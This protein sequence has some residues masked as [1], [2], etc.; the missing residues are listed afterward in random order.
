MMSDYLSNLSARS[1]NLA[2]V[3]QPRLAS[4]F[5]PLLSATSPRPAWQT[6]DEPAVAEFRGELVNVE[7]RHKDLSST[8]ARDFSRPQRHEMP[9]HEH[10]HFDAP[11]RPMTAHLRSPDQPPAAGP[12]SVVSPI[13]TA[14]SMLQP[15]PMQH[16]DLQGPKSQPPNPIL[17]TGRDE[18]PTAPF[19]NQSETY[20]RPVFEPAVP[21][22]VIEH[23]AE[24]VTP[25]TAM[26]Q[27]EAASLRSS[28]EEPR[29]RKFLRS[30][31]P[32]DQR[33]VQSI[34]ARI[35]VQ[36]HIASYVEQ[37]MPASPQ[38]LE[39]P[40]PAPTIQVTIGRIEVRA[41]PPVTQPQ[42]QRSAPQV[43]SLDEYLRQRAGGGNQ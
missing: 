43:M 23:A 4:R 34:P 11:L 36:P 14:P 30:A 40:K 33:L 1:L 29:P 25:R 42:R 41:T 38:S 3:L 37:A 8:P 16:A 7:T 10:P 31:T 35:V 19:R 22:A 27:D 13:H 17:A 21:H 9:M 15:R 28:G 12:V 6:V 5:E 26:A 18:T 32:A 20:N 2:P 39:T 24:S